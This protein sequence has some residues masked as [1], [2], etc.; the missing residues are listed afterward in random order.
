[1]CRRNAAGSP[2][3]RLPFTPPHRA[4]PSP[5]LGAAN[6]PLRRGHAQGRGGA[7]RRRAQARALP[8][9]GRARSLR[10]GAV[11]RFACQGGGGRRRRAGAAHARSRR[12]WGG[13][14]RAAG[15]CGGCVREGEGDGFRNR[16]RRA[17]R[18]AG[19][20]GKEK[21]GGEKK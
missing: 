19:W 17:P 1:M 8:S 9:R 12:R 11:P 21:R 2:P 18:P 5:P 16:R 20:K 10:A 3:S 14:G 6:R 13:G 7:S 4:A 15:L